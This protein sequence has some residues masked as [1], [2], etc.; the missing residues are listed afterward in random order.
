MTGPAVAALAE[1]TSTVRAC[2]LLGRSRAG[3]YRAT[4]PTPARE[5][6][7]RPAPPNALTPQERQHIL[8][9]LSSDRF[10]DKAVAQAWATLLDEGI[11]LGSQSTMHRCLRAAGARGD[12]RAQATHPAKVKPEL[13]AT[14]PNQVWSWDITKLRTLVRGVYYDLY[15]ILDIYSRYVVGWTVAAREDSAIAADL[16]NAAI[17]QHSA[18]HT[19]HADRGTSMTSK[20]V[21]QLMATSGSP[22]HTPARMLRMTTPTPRPR[23]RP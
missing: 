7:P 8:D 6:K 21:A 17:E 22:A 15:V 4:R 3:H 16:I 18:P 13:V 5:H 1:V 9:V 23:S 12:R 14:G 11:Y 10:V 2:T 19:I 20:Q